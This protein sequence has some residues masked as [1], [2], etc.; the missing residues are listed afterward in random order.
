[1]HRGTGARGVVEYQ[2]KYLLVKNK[3]SQADFWCLPGGNVED[4]EDILSALTREM[5]E[6]TGIKPLIG[7][8][9]FVHQMKNK[10]GDWG[11]PDFIFH[12][13]NGKD[14]LNIDISKTSHG[15]IELLDIGFKDIGD[16]FILPEFLKTDLPKLKKLDFIAPAQIK[17]DTFLI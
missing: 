13:K 7:N 15:E 11:H 17:L 8:L 3:A 5:V 1:M 2:G 12:I 6:E 9:L 10:K 14:Y 16:V 4:G